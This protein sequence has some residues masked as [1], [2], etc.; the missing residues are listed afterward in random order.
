MGWK[1]DKVMKIGRLSDK[2]FVGKTKKLTFNTFSCLK[3]VEKFEIRSD[4]IGS[5]ELTTA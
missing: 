2:N 4:M 1:R 3:P 5:W